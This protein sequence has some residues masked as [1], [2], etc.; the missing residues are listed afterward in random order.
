M[1][2][3]HFHDVNITEQ[4]VLLSSVVVNNTDTETGKQ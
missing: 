4:N 3:G 1:G 2:L